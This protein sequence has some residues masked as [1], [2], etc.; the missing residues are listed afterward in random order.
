MASEFT[1]NNNRELMA[2]TGGI[3]GASMRVESSR[4]SRHNVTFVD[5]GSQNEITN[6]IKVYEM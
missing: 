5:T 2:G 3:L 6:I 1:P 4:M